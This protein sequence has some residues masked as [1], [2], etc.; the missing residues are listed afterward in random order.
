MRKSITIDKLWWEYLAPKQL[1]S[2]R[3]EVESLINDFIR[4]DMGGEWA[5]V[6]ENPNG[7]FRVKPSQR[8]P[9]LHITFLG[10]RPGFIAPFNIMREGHRAVTSVSKLESDKELDA[11][12]LVIA[13]VISVDVVTDP[14]FIQA[15][16]T[17]SPL[18]STPRC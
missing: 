11:D 8:I 17:C 15:A 10:K 7:V 2:R 12:E 6:A 4:A 3:R 14:L 18:I 5:S 1:I 9:I 13:P 16:M